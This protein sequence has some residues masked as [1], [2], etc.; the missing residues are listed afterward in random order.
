M[1]R[2]PYTVVPKRT[3]AIVIWDWGTDFVG[4]GSDRQEHY[5]AVYLRLQAITPLAYGTR[6]IPS[7]RSLCVYVEHL[8]KSTFQ[9]RNFPPRARAP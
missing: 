7:S 6:L 3:Y 5:A 2:D 4:N 9:N 8:L 1:A